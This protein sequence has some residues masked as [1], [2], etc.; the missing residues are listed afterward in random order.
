LTGSARI[1]KGYELP[2][3]AVANVFELTDEELTA[4][5]CRRCRKRCTTRCARWALRCARRVAR[6]AHLSGSWATNAPGWRR[7]SVRVTPFEIEQ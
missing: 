1:E 2:A 4:E 3:E 7:Y 5:R 6:R